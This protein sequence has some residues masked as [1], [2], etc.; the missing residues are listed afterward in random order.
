MRV[1]THRRHDDTIAFT[2]CIPGLRL[3]DSD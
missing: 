1:A 2:Q 3:A